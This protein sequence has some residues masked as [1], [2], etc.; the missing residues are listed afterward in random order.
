MNN[1]RSIKFDIIGV[2]DIPTNYPT[3]VV[4]KCDPCE[5]APMPT[6]VFLGNG[7][8]RRTVPSG[9]LGPNVE[10]GNKMIYR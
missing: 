1:E 7:P 4:T 3:V 9:L 6:S 10:I 8:A 5:Q 2:A